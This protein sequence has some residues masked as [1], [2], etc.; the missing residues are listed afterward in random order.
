M[1]AKTAK[2]ATK[3]KAAAK[4]KSPSKASL[5]KSLNEKGIEV[6]E[7]AVIADLQHRLKHWTGDAGYNVRLHKGVGPK[8]EGHPLSLLS[9]RKAMYWLP[10][11]AFADEIIRTR[12]VLVVK[13]GLPLNNALVI[14]VPV[15]YGGDNGS[16][17]SA[18][19]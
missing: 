1:A 9:D 14:D 15:D 19:S 5:V 7:G 16:N 17:D 6:P 8:W 4:P 3:K 11:S 13:R 12:L 10:A 18:D 2:K